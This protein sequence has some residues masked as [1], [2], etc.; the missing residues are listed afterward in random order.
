MDLTTGLAKALVNFGY[1]YF[2]SKHTERI[3]R[4]LEEGGISIEDALRAEGD[5]FKVTTLIDA[6]NKASTY[7][8]ANLLKDV[9]LFFEENFSNNDRYDDIFF[10]TLS[11]LSELSDREIRLIGLLDYFYQNDIENNPDHELYKKYFSLVKENSSWGGSPFDTFYF[12]AS[13]KLG[14]SPDIISG[15]MSRLTRSGLLKS[16]GMDG[17]ALY[18]RYILSALYDEIR[19]RIIMSMETSYGNSLKLSSRNL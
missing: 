11:I 15:M 7:E 14:V 4:E 18:Q 6:L 10:E 2:K 3:L 19:T 12:I 17:N 9:Y 8:K 13:E 1:K 5:I 16:S